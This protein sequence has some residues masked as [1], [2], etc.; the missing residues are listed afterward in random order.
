MG[1]L[2]GA[3]QPVLMLNNPL[4]KKF[5]IIPNLNIPWW[6]LQQF[7]LVLSL[8]AQEMEVAMKFL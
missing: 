6:K 5:S 8:V 4:V 1:T 2:I 7:L 3:G